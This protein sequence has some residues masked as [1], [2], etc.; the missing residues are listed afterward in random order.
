MNTNQNYFDDAIVIDDSDSSSSRNLRNRNSII[1]ENEMRKLDPVA[2][3]RIRKLVESTKFLSD[4]DPEKSKRERRKLTRKCY[5]SAPASRAQNIYDEKGRYRC[6]G[7]NDCDCLD[8]QCTGCHFPCQTCKSPMCG[9]SCRV[10][11]KWTYDCIEHDGK[12][13]VYRNRKYETKLLQ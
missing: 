7:S 4:F 8:P 11:R 13:L 2:E 12:D 6:D 3:K 9:P 5:T 10:N 1:S